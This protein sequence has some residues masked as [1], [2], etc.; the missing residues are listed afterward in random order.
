MNID[1]NILISLWKNY[2]NASKLLVDAMD[3]TNNEVGEFAEKLVA[4]YYNANQLQ[5]SSKSADLETSDKKLIQVKSRKMDKLTSQSLGV[6]RSWDFDILVIVLFD[7]LG[8]ILKAIEIKTN[9]AKQ[10]AKENEYQN[11]FILT[12][13]KELLENSKT[14]DLTKEFQDI[15]EGKTSNNLEMTTVKEHEIIVVPLQQKRIINPRNS[16]IDDEV[17]KIQN[18]IPKW[19]QNKNQ[20]NSR[21]L[22]AFI[23]LVNNKDGFVFLSDL[24]K[25]ASFKTFME[26]YNQMKNFGEKNHGKIF[27]ERDD[28]KVYFWNEVKDYIWNYYEKCIRK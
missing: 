27:E 20:Y 1:F 7:K 14:K 12:T 6:I 8:N 15:L 22:Y 21:I 17:K 26:N 18:R 23:K 2:N 24:Q 10:L 28:G 25:E 19:F 5:V 13:S 16:I 9:D 11:G 4:K 3:G